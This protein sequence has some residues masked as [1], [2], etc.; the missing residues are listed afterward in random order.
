MCEGY[1]ESI[2]EGVAG[3]AA[4]GGVGD[5]GGVVGA[6][7]DRDGGGLKRGR[8]EKWRGAERVIEG[9]EKDRI[10]CVETIRVGRRRRSITPINRSRFHR[11]DP[12]LLN[13]SFRRIPAGKGS[14]VPLSFLFALRL[15]QSISCIIT[16]VPK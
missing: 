9:V 14:Y 7:R 13:A 16:L 3:E 8:T 2:G 4:A 12:R 11:E 5:S 15:K 10:N 6:R 1:T